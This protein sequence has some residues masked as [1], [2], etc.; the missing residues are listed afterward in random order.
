[1]PSL[2]VSIDTRRLDA[3]LETIG[4]DVRQALLSALKPVAQAEAQKARD[5]AAAHIRFLGKYPGQYLASIY[6]GTFDQPGRVGG[7]VRSGNFLAG[8]LE[9]G[10]TT[11]PHEIL[12]T[13]GDV[14]AFDGS[15]GQVFA[16][17][18][19]HPGATIPA[20]PALT[21]AFDQD[22]DSIEDLIV[23]TVKRAVKF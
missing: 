14:L 18:V 4:D 22:K 1:M 7:F 15:A 9:S 21:P 3:H 5:I 19:H 13:A 17:A 16:K 2:S 8:I 23:S 6:G 10:A 12:P 11:P 20:N